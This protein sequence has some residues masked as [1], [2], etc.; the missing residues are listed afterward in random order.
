MGRFSQLPHRSYLI[1]GLLICLLIILV[2]ALLALNSKGGSDVVATDANR[3]VMAVAS[4]TPT[5]PDLKQ[6]Q[7][8]LAA[9]WNNYK[10]RFIQS[11]GRVLDPQADSITTSEGQS[12]ALL[13]AVWQNDH[14]TFDKVLAWSQHNLQKRTDDK[15]FAYKWGKATD[16]SWKIL[17]VGAATD[18]DSDVALALLFA[19]KRWA[20]VNYQK[21][22]LEITDSLWQKMVATVQGKPFI[23]GGDWAPAQARPAL[24]PS[25]LA[26]YAY[27][28]FALVDPT[29]DWKGLVD[30]SYEVIRECSVIQLGDLP[31]AKLPPD[32]CGV[33]KQTGNFATAQDYP[34]LDTNYGYDAFRTMWRVA[35]DYRWFGEKRALD[36]LQRSDTLR[37]KWQQ[38]GKLVAVYDHSGKAVDSREDLATYAGALA[39]FSLTEPALADALVATKYLPAYKQVDNT[40]PTQAFVGWGDSQNYYNQNWVWFG[41]ALYSNSLPNLFT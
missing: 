3:T 32:W 35:L 33:D 28:I 29:H 40:D 9:S 38:E 34:H 1:V 12:Y 25:Y 19:S 41:L 5:K 31:S 17:D 26:P 20:D 15:L 14:A 2:A 36:Y 13:R 16:G 30:T 27:R 37:Q 4:P 6:I 18:A 7:S 11:D 24:N 22:A 23:T 8:Q 39:N 21:T 10:Q